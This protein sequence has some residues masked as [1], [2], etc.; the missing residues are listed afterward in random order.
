MQYF[1]ILD[2]LCHMSS[3]LSALLITM[4]QDKK[5]SLLRKVISETI[6]LLDDVQQYRDNI[7]VSAAK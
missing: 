6:S 7:N 2:A 4:E 3:E 5:S 1:T